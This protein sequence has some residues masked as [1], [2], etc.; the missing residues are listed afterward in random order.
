MENECRTIK[1]YSCSDCA[2]STLVKMNTISTTNDD[3]Q[4]MVE[5]F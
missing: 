3:D 4:C 5:Y 1:C 2:N